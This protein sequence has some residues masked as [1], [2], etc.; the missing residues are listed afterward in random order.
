MGVAEPLGVGAC[1]AVKLGVLLPLTLGVAVA[2]AVS[3]SLAVPDG[4]SVD[5]GVGE[6]EHT[7]LCARRLMPRS[8]AAAPAPIAVHVR[9]VLA[10]DHV[11]TTDARPVETE[12]HA[13][14]PPPRHATGTDAERTSA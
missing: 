5:E 3:D 11:E 4:V 14:A 9:P 8:G 7:F 2:L 1:E 6:G 10:L 13:P 12:G